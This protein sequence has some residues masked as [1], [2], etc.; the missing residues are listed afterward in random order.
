[1]SRSLVPGVRQLWDPVPRPLPNQFE[2]M[3]V[4]LPFKKDTVGDP[5]H[6]PL[7]RMA[8]V[9]VWSG[10]V[11]IVNVDRDP[12]EKANDRHLRYLPV[13]TERPLN[14]ISDHAPNR[15][16]RDHL[17]YR[18]RIGLDLRCD[19]PD[20]LLRP[21]RDLLT[22]HHAHRVAWCS[23]AVNYFFTETDLLFL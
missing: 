7:A 21:L 19:H 17:A 1:M 14:A 23:R 13:F 10:V 3:A 4:H 9:N 8:H 20:I 6:H 11:T 22:L 5:Q 12:V 18:P 15:S 2:C 16:A